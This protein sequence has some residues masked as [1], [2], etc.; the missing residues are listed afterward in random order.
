MYLGTTI[1]GVLLAAACAMPIVIS[2][3]NRSKRM[4]HFFDLLKNYASQLNGQVD[5]Y[6]VWNGTAIGVDKVK[7]KLFYIQTNGE[8]RIEKELILKAVRHCQVEKKIRTVNNGGESAKVFERIDLR[9]S[10]TDTATP[11]VLLPFYNNNRDNLSIDRELELANKWS[12]LINELLEQQETK[13]QRH[14]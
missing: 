7:M 13:S 2:N 6:D 8:S 9:F 10:F 5:Q 3:R 4:K 12:V 14:F 1:T 11:E